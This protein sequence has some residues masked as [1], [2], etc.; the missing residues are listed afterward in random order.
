MRVQQHFWE[1]REKKKSGENIKVNPDKIYK[2]PPEIWVPMKKIE[3]EIFSLIGEEFHLKKVW[4]NF[5]KYKQ[6]KN[7]EKDIFLF[8]G[9]KKRGLWVEIRFFVS[10]APEPFKANTRRFFR[11][12]ELAS[13]F[14]LVLG[15]G[16][17]PIPQYSFEIQSFEIQP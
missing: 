3:G 7:K 14:R 11:V 17:D 16:G 13:N 6:K 9:V 4:K 5:E 15:K 1:L 10:D 8:L 2:L 12:P